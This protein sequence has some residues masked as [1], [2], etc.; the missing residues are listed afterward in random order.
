MTT[1]N[2]MFEVCLDQSD[3][4]CVRDRCVVLNGRRSIDEV[5]YSATLK[6][7]MTGIRHGAWRN[8]AIANGISTKPCEIIVG[9]RVYGQRCCCGVSTDYRARLA[10]ANP[11]QA[12]SL[13]AWVI[14]EEPP[15]STHNTRSLVNLTCAINKQ[16]SPVAG[17]GDSANDERAWSSRYK[18]GRWW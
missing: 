12:I 7:V 15:W 9:L 14:G 17:R 4:A 3:A 10:L 6:P 16:A 18:I 1:L 13:F 2:Q 5:Y 8:V 11:H